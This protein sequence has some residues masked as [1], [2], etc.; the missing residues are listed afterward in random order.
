MLMEEDG[1]LEQVE[2]ELKDV[3]KEFRQ[4]DVDDNH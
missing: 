2:I 1:I 3:R 4:E